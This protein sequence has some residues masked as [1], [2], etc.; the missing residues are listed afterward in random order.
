M[1]FIILT[2]TALFISG[3]ATVETPIDESV[4]AKPVSHAELSNTSWLID[5]TDLAMKFTDQTVSGSTGCNTF[6]GAYQARGITN[7]LHNLT[8]GPLAM[9]RRA[10]MEAE[11]A[12]LEM[13]I[14]QALSQTTGYKRIGDG[15]IVLYNE[16]GSDV[17]TLK[18]AG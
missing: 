2:I 1:R 14:T 5:D 15:V 13:S 7:G 16:N 12:A 17:L 10:C 6:S 4:S 18:P 11:A 9:T 3:C 8:M